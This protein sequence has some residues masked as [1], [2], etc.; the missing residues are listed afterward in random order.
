MQMI[1]NEACQVGSWKRKARVHINDQVF[2]SRDDV[3]HQEQ[4]ST[5]A[6]LF[7]ALTAV[8]DFYISSFTFFWSCHGRKLFW[9]CPNIFRFET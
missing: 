1:G 5:L 9:S 6:G 4:W 7:T 3:R 8:S 2:T